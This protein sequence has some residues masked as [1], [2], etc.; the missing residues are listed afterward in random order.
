S[1]NRR[2]TQPLKKRLRLTDH[3]V[4]GISMKI[5]PEV[6]AWLLEPLWCLVAWSLVFAYGTG[7][8]RKNAYCTAPEISNLAV[9]VPL[10]PGIS[11]A[12]VCQL[13]MLV[14][15]ERSWMPSTL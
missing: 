1:R 14:A 2:K 3:P 9:T 7:T 8:T 13:A 12:T 11:C 15:F 10:V 5:A 4:T 6:G